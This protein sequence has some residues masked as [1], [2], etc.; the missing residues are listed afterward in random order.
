MYS[1]Y[2]VPA[3]IGLEACVCAAGF[4]V[5]WLAD[6]VDV[7]VEVLAGALPPL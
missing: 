1:T 2:D 3:G 7:V 6:V 4:A 5:V